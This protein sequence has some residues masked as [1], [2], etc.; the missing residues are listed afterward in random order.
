MLQSLL[1]CS[2]YNFLNESNRAKTFKTPRPRDQWLCDDSLSGWYRFGG[3][4]G[5]QMPKSC[6][7]MYHCGT[8]MP[9]WLNGSHPAV[10][11]GAVQRTVCF[12]AA[13]NC[14]YHSTNITVRNCG[15]FYVYRLKQPPTC[16][17]RYCGNGVTP[18]T[19][20][21]G[22]FSYNCILG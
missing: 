1:G 21:K 3:G 11:D 7:A 2:S 10:A 22:T 14:C 12:N 6:V 4:A 13:N 9:G 19:P 18:V 16:H 5:N 15:G 17:L 20:G 8:A